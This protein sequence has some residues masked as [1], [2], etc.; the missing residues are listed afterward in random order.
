MNKCFQQGLLS[1]MVISL[2][3]CGGGGSGGGNK[4]SAPAS[5]VA[6]SSVA[7][8]SVAMSSS[9]STETSSS[10]DAS[11]SV[12][13]SSTPASSVAPSSTPASSSEASSVAL[14]SASSSSLEASSS[15]PASSAPASSSPASSSAASSSS[16]PAL[17][18]VFLDSAVAGIGYRTSPSGKGGFT[19]AQGEYEYE[20]GDKV[21]FFIGDL[22]LPEVDAK[23]VITPLDIAQTDELTDQVVLNIA[24]LLQSLDSDGDASNGITI[25]YELAET[26]ATAINFEQ[27]ASTF[28]SAITPLVTAAE[29]TLKTVQAAQEHLQGTVESLDSLSAERL[30]GTWLIEGDDYKAVVA[31][32]DTSRYMSVEVTET[33]GTNLEVGSY[34]WD[35]STGVITATPNDETGNA[36]LGLQSEQSIYVISSAGEQLLISEQGDEEP[37]TVMTKLTSE[38]GIVGGWYLADS[39]FIALAA[40]TGT[41]YLMGQYEPNPE[42]TN[43][44]SGV[45]YGTYSHNAETNAFVVDTLE[46]T[47]GQWGFSHPCA[48][49]DQETSND[50]SC[51]P[52]GADIVQTITRTGTAI[53]FVSQADTI[54]NNGVEDPVDFIEVG[55]P[56]TNEPIELEVEVTNTVTAAA[57]GELFTVNGAT[58]QCGLIEEHQVGQTETFPETWILNPNYGQLSS[59]SDEKYETE[60]PYTDTGAFDPVFNKLQISNAGAKVNLCATGEAQCSGDTVFYERASYTWTADINLDEGAPTLASGEIV[61][62]RRLSWN[63][64]SDVSICTIR[65]SVSATRLPQP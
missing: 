16:T 20:T 30:V 10:M 65:Y 45:E 55:S 64:T 40:F 58:M 60:E 19:S 17:T 8:S 24:I 32:L 34:V 33:E 41:H 25:N 1:A 49:L 14:S 5:S 29:G 35:A 37:P 6:P 13:V 38:S 27:D 7:A 51:G 12:E 57:Q 18:G 54:A 15:A 44:Q 4:S 56:T 23:G 48:I 36:D 53:R 31:F 47:N 61:E 9:S 46:D 3:A 52:N 39:G 26:S 2:V 21:T 42:D 22:E 11:S 43:G 59:V 28:S 62:T 50:L 63:L